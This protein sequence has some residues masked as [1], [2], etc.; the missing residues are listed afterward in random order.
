MGVPAMRQ[1]SLSQT[2]SA[3]GH[4][5]YKFD[6]RSTCCFLVLGSIL[7]LC[8]GFCA[9]TADTTQTSINSNAVTCQAAIDSGIVQGVLRG[10]S[11]VYLGI[12]YA[13]SPAGARRWQ[14]SASVTPWPGVKSFVMFGNMCPQVQIIA[15]VTKAVGDEDCLNLNVFAPSGATSPLPVIFFIHGSGN[16]ASSNRSEAGSSLDGQYL[17]EHGPAVVVVINYRLGALGWLAHPALDAESATGT[18]GNYGI[19]DQ[20][21]ALKCVQ[22][23]IAAFGGDP[24]RV[25][26]TG[27]S[28][29]AQ[30]VGAL[31]ASPAGQGLFASV[32]VDGGG[33]L[34]FETALADYEASVGVNVVTKLGCA[35]A[36]D[37]SACLRA[38]PSATIVQKTLGVSNVFES[39][40]YRAIIDGV[41]L[42]DTVLAV[43]KQGAQNHVPFIIGGGAREAANPNA[44]FALNAIPTEADYHAAVYQAFGQP[45]SDQ[46]L[47][48]YPSANYA[49]TRDAIIA[50]STDYRWLCPA[51]QLARAVSNSQKEPVYR[52][53]FTHALSN[54]PVATAQGAYHGQELMFIFHAF[55]SGGL[56]GTTTPTPDELTLSDQMI[57]YWTRFAA[58]GDPNGGDALVWPV[59]GQNADNRGRG[60]TFFATD[61][62]GDDKKDTFLQF[63]TPLAEGAGF[64]SEVCENFWDVLAGDT[65]NGH[66]EGS[67]AGDI[68]D[69]AGNEAFVT[70]ADL[71]N[72]DKVPIQPQG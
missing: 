10:Q 69:D 9:E 43:A 64:H 5:Q 67:I 58:T 66:G 59:Y 28:S 4:M 60:N 68:D 18:S 54:P 29:G 56:F 1:A 27:H 49:T 61:A 51:S 41:V 13:A 14:P 36:A 46:I 70:D 42:N 45:V 47:A 23:N 11:C 50:L 63:D 71:D 3:G 31:F 7:L 53:V 17:A 12:P 55:S 35:N 72:D 8:P 44:G 65:N 30:D 57:G 20:I 21:A 34:H 40:T 25:M 6:F 15:G 48:L 26:I 38:V 62:Q 22:R 16:R 19:L 52:F 2:F 39:G 37:I 24:S 32:L 33:F